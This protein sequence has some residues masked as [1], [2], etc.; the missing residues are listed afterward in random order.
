MKYK[1]KETNI[2]KLKLFL[3]KIKNNTTKKLKNGK[4]I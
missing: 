3:E 4:S 2:E 1:V